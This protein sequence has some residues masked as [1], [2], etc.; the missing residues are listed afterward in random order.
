[1]I[2]F[3][4]A[5]SFYLLIPFL[6]LCGLYA[7]SSWDRKKEILKLGEWKLIQK[8][9]PIKALIRRKKK[10]VLVLIALFFLIL[11]ATGPQMGSTMKEVKSRGVDVFIAI[12]TSKSMLAE[13][14]PPSRLEHAKRALSLLIQKCAGNRIG[15]IAFA[16]YAVI[17]CPLTID[18]E[19]ATMFLDILDTNAVPEQ[20]TSIGDAIRLAN[21]SFNKDDKAG[22]VL[23]LL[24]DGEDHKSDPMGA[25]QLAKDKGVVIFTIGLGTTKGEVIKNR[26][27]NGKV[28]EFL[29]HKG[30]MVVSHMDDTLLTQIASLTGGK[31]YHASS[32]DREIDEISDVINGYDKKEFSSKIHQRHEERYALFALIAFILLLIEFFFAE[33]EG[34]WERIKTVL[35]SLGRNWLS[36]KLN[37]APLLLIFIF[38][39]QPTAHADMKDHIMRGNKLLKKKDLVGARGEF[40]SAQIDAPEAPFIPYNI[41]LTYHLEGNW[42]MAQ[43]QYEKALAMTKDPRLQAQIHYNMGH[44]QFYKGDRAA[45]IDQFKTSLKLNPKD[46]DAKYNIEYIKSG[47]TPKNPPQQQNQQDKNGGD[48]NQ[49]NGQ[50]KGQEQN[51]QQK[52]KKPGEMSKENAEQILQMMKD[53]EKENLKNAK[54]M[55]QGKPKDEKKNDDGEDW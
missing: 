26:D 5:Q 20:G 13:D 30:E 21:D 25:A 45:A 53:Q 35:K 36:K 52:E 7:W 34:Q 15:I 29:K 41:A 22:K 43:K 9:V 11:A 50:G 28:I 37:I 24:T 14:I 27:E 12:D 10:D 51:G 23:I 49:Q 54:R 32:S 19:S 38:A 3:H 4:Y 1:M 42:D 46:V 33:N 16:K 8:L 44:L 39:Y 40:E 18:A 6:L 17:Q 2:N 48:K 55:Q 47:K 31:Y